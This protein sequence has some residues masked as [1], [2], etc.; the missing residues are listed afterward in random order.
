MWRICV[1]QGSAVMNAIN[2]WLGSNLGRTSTWIINA[3]D[4]TRL[5]FSR[6]LVWGIGAPSG[7]NPVEKVYVARV[8]VTAV[9]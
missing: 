8:A 7:V 9:P 2:V 6:V 1:Q 5:I 4:V 3:L